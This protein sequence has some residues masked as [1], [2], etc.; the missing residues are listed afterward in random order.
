[1]AFRFRRRRLPHLDIDGAT[2]FVTSCLAN[3]IP[4]LGLRDLA[5]YER[6]LASRRPVNLSDREWKT[7]CWKLAFARADEWLDNQPACRQLDD[8]RLA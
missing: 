6:T 4:A 8:P 2:Y 1:M 7:R 3:S 5:E